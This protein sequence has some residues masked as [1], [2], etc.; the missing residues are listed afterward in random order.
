MKKLPLLLLLASLNAFSASNSIVAIVDDELITY[1]MIGVKNET[2]AAKLAS[3]NRQI[4]DILKM[5][6]VQQLELTLKDQA[7]NDALNYIAQQNSLSLSQ[8]QASPKFDQVLAD[9]K[10]T[11]IF[12]GLKAFI[13]DQ[14]GLILTQ[15]EIDQALKDNP[16]TQ[17]D[18][19]EQIRIAQIAISSIEQSSLLQ[20]QDTLIKAFLTDLADQINQ[21]KSFSALAKLHSQDESYQNGGESG[22]LLT[23]QLPKVF[24]Q[25]LDTL[26]VGEVSSPFKAGNSWRLIKII[27]KRRVDNHIENIEAALVRQK[28]D[29]YF[30]AW[31]NKLRQAAYV[32]IY[33]QK[34]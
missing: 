27:E 32:E 13:I 2:K 26:K 33:D 23:A 3:I 30:N 34:L 6:Q 11:L 24:T 17:T 28:K 14:A 4:D 8:L 25:V 7:I 12:N 31:V 21:G 29:D 15:A 5:R 16:S 9:V 22:W 1:D 19:S 18:I 10:K 20:S